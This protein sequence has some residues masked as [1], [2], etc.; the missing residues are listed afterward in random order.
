MH[1]NANAISNAEMISKWF[2]TEETVSN[3]L[4]C[5]IFC[6]HCMRKYAIVC[7]ASASFILRHLLVD[8]SRIGMAQRVTYRRRCS[9]ATKSNKTR[10][11]KTPGLFL[12]IK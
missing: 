4:N 10:M 11:V 8:G 9:Y 3:I 12:L 2:L 1:E 5:R 7:Q 6:M